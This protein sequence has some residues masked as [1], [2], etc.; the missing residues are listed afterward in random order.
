[1]PNRRFDWHNHIKDVEKEYKAVRFAITRLN[2]Q[3][4]STPDILI[5]KDATRTNIRSADSNLEGTYIVRLFAA[6]EAALRSYD[7]ARHRDPDREENASVLIDSTGGRRARRISAKDRGGAHEV[8]RL[9]NYWA[10]ESDQAPPP[11]TI[12][13]ARARLEKFL[14]RLPEEWP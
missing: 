10:H 6:F 3:I 2:D 7:R 9:R 11:M 8:R 4:A 13:E 5:G 14:A 1:M 12:S